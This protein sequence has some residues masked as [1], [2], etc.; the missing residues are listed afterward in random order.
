MV[1]LLACEAPLFAQTQ[2]EGEGFYVPE[3]EADAGRKL[4]QH[5]RCMHCHLVAGDPG[6]KAPVEPMKA[7]VLNY[8]PNSS[9]AEIAQAIIS[10]SHTIS[11]GFGEGTPEDV[12]KSPMRDYADIL[13]LRDFQNIVAYLKSPKSAMPLP[14]NEAP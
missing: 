13:T 12:Q 14:E 4:F 1:F 8:G 11:E 5:H 2:T 9:P 6:L 10:P 7:P 3:G